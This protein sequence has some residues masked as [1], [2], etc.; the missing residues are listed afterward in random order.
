ML[1]NLPP[2]QLTRSTN[3]SLHVR[4]QL[5]IQ[6]S[7]GWLTGR[8]RSLEEGMISRRVPAENAEYLAF[9]TRSERRIDENRADANGQRLYPPALQ[10]PD[11]LWMDSSDE[12]S[13]SASQ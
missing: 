12:D 8:P 6:A 9:C 3:N 4:T 5:P 10:L 7:E 11:R 13:E 2:Q 1:R